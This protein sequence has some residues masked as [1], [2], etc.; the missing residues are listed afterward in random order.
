MLDR[1]ISWR[2]PGS[3]MS[4]DPVRLRRATGLQA[5]HRQLPAFADVSLGAASV[6]SGPGA[7]GAPD[8]RWR[9]QGRLDRIVLR[10]ATLADVIAFERIDLA[11]P[12]WM[13]GPGGQRVSCSILTAIPSGCSSRHGGSSGSHD[14]TLPLGQAVPSCCMLGIHDY[15]L[16]VLTGVLLEP[17]ARSGHGMF[18][19]AA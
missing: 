6:V 18:W 17:H 8:A 16:F 19:A 13:I 5:R 2:P 15:W 10:V 7:S 14:L 11:F 4:A 1:R 9:R 12:Q 3:R